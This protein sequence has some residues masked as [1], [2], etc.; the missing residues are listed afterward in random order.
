MIGKIRM[1]FMETAPL[2]KGE[3]A[4]RIGVNPATVGGWIRQGHIA[5]VQLPSGERRIP[6]EEVERL[7]ELRRVKTVAG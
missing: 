4:R 6:V 3:F 2:R 1:V 5:Y 7:L